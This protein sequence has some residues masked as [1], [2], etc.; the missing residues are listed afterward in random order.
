MGAPIATRLAR[1]RVDLTVWNRTS[2]VAE[3]F[4]ADGVRVAVNPADAARQIVLTVLP[5]LPQVREVLGRPDGLLAGWKRSG[6]DAPVLVVHGTVSPIGVRELAEE[7]WAESGVTVVDAPVSGGTVGARAGTLSVMVGAQE[8]VFERVLPVF[9]AYAETAIRMGQV[10]AGSMAKACNQVVVAGTVAAVSE[11]VALA[12][13]SGLDVADL[14]RVLTGGL[15]DSE[16][17]RQKAQKWVSRDFTEGGSARNQLKDLDIVLSAAG[18]A[19]LDLRVAR[20]VRALFAEMI[21]RGDGDL[22]H[23]GVYRTIDR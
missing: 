6:I 23:T 7:A 12:R 18:D 22:D 17:L 19:G 8:D 16:V 9:A 21:S 14:M 20:S 3:R 1:A 5:D 13:R 10:G 4:R 11:A 15:A 2:S